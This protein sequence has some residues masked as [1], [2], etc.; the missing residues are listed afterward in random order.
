MPHSGQLACTRR[1]VLL[2]DP[3]RRESALGIELS[4]LM[5]TLPTLQGKNERIKKFLLPRQ[6]ANISRYFVGIF[7]AML[8]F[9]IQNTTR[10]VERLRSVRT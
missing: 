9:S 5:R 7:I 1:S 3:A 6:Y 2:R 4:N 10:E 8:P